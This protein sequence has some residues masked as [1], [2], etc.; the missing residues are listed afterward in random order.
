MALWNRESWSAVAF[1]MAGSCKL[2][3]VGV[4]AGTT[5]GPMPAIAG[6]QKMRKVSANAGSSYD[7][8][9]VVQT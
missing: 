3:S 8:T 5:P 2:E 7:E 6:E 4:V 1:L 9:A